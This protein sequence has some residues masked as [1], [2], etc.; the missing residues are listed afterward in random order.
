METKLEIQFLYFEVDHEVD[1]SKLRSMETFPE[2][3]VEVIIQFP[4]KLVHIPH[5]SYVRFTSEHLKSFLTDAI[6]WLPKEE[7]PKMNEVNWKFDETGTM[8]H[9]V[10]LKSHTLTFLK[11]ISMETQTIP[12]GMEIGTL[13]LCDDHPFTMTVE[14]FDLELNTCTCV[15]FSFD[16][17][18]EWSKNIHRSTYNIDELYIVPEP[19]CSPQWLRTVST[20]ISIINTHLGID[21]PMSIQPNTNGYDVQYGDRKVSFDANGEFKGASNAPTS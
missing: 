16:K 10:Q 4:G 14:R 15:W 13:V 21:R 2:D 9:E 18:G 6:G 19:D 20:F 11:G 12:N 8:H 17:S 5:Q 7:G 1:P 3:P